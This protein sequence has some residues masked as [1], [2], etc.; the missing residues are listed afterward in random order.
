MWLYRGEQLGRPRELWTRKYR[1]SL[2][3]DIHRECKLTSAVWF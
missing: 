3:H 1:L 2:A